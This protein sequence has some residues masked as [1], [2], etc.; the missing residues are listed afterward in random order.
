VRSYDNGW[1]IREMPQPKCTVVSIIEDD[2]SFRRAAERLLR[3][4]GFEA[5]TFA[6]AEEFLKNAVPA[7][8]ACLVVDLHLPGMSGIDLI[9]YLAKLSAPPPTIFITAREDENLRQRACLIP[10]S[11][12]LRKP[13]TG[14][15]LLEAMRSLLKNCASGEERSER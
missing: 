4:L 2:P 15:S 10:N 14:Q 6:S 3:A 12:Y 11:V 5:H 7:S 9:H 1:T 13:F 8:C